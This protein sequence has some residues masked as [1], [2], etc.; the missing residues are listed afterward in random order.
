MLLIKKELETQPF[1]TNLSFSCGY[2]LFEFNILRKPSK[3]GCSQLNH[4]LFQS[5][6]QIHLPLIH[7]LTYLVL[8][9]L[10]YEFKKIHKYLSI[11][12]WLSRHLWCQ[13]LTLSPSPNFHTVWFLNHSSTSTSP[14]TFKKSFHQINSLATSLS[15]LHPN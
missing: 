13:R 7:S 5:S 2:N 6:F 15:L 4:C 10:L 11:R 12:V 14:L 3:I 9:F 8:T 1:H